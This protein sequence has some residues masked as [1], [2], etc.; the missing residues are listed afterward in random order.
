MR[1]LR[2]VDHCL[3]ICSRREISAVSVPPYLLR[4]MCNIM[5]A[6]AKPTLDRQ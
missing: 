6:Q 5:E 2:S 3:N 4:T 1:F